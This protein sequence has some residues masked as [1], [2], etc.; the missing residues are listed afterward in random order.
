MDYSNLDLMEPATHAGEPWQMYDWIRDNEPLYWDSHNAVWCVSRYDD[1]VK[2]AKDPD[3]FTSSEGNVPGLPPDPS[4]INIDGP[5]H[6]ARRKLVRNRFAPKAIAK[7]EDHIRASVIELLDEAGEDGHTEFLEDVA[8]RLPMRVIAD[9]CGIPREMHDQCR[10]WLD[11]FCGG[12][13]GPKFVTDEVNEN[14]FGFAAYHFQLVEERKAEPKDDLLSMWVNATV[15]GQPLEEEA[16]LFEHTMMIV[17]GSETTRNAISGGL[18][19]LLM[20]PEAMAHLRTHPEDI[21]NAAEEMLRWVS[22]FIRMSRTATKDV[23]WYGKTI[24]EGEEI[25]MLYPA[26]NRDPSKYAHPNTFDIHRSFKNS[27][28]SFGYGKHFCLGARLARVEMRILFEELLKRWDNIAL[29]GEPVWA[30]SSF[31][32]GIVQLPLTFTRHD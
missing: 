10:A 31:I 17:G 4:F 7:L 29:D 32:R 12:G 2:V 9:M 23:E 30:E 19:Q 28:L 8:A 18:Y 21:P 14:F 25:M 5:V 26:A 11:V 24:K 27:V 22:P 13:N 1:V 16:L 20:N 15:D 6:V 3:T